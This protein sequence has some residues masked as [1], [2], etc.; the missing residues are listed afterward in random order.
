MGFSQHFY[1]GDTEI[2]YVI[3]GSVEY[4]DNGTIITIEAL[5]VT[6][7]PSGSG[8]SI[9]NKGSEPLEIIALIIY[10]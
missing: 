1:S 4:N 8:H 9:N 6:F 3:S 2:Y 5:D 10:S 7:T